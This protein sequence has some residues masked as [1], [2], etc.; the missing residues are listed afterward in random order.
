VSQ[1]VV[2]R[3]G[4]EIF[5][6]AKKWAGLG[7]LTKLLT[8]S[9]SSWVGSDYPFDNSTYRNRKFIFK[10]LTYSNAPFVYAFTVI[11]LNFFFFKYVLSIS[12]KIFNL[13]WVPPNLVSLILRETKSQV[14]RTPKERIWWIVMPW[15]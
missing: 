2:V 6:L 12:K 8:C 7:W 5:W 9:W 15:C 10:S 3:T 4:F 13:C 11:I 14:W 1:S